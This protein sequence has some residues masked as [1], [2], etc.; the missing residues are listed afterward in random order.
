MESFFFT[1]KTTFC[2]FVIIFILFIKTG[3]DDVLLYYLEASKGHVLLT[4][5]ASFSYM[6]CITISAS[7][8]GIP[9]VHSLKQRAEND[10][11]TKKSWPLK[12][13]QVL[14]GPMEESG[15]EFTMFFGGKNF[16]WTA[17][18]K[19]KLAEF[20]FCLVEISRQTFRT[21]PQLI[22]ISLEDLQAMGEV[23]AEKHRGIERIY[24]GNIHVKALS[25]LFKHRDAASDEKDIMED[26]MQV[27]LMTGEEASDVQ[28]VEK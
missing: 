15:D 17:R 25:N 10:Y 12:A 18:N 20:L 23:W 28:F 16:L 3:N 8:S 14:E 22:K 26:R 4:S 9:R 21:V 24:A 11:H 19:D 1:S 27:P 13:L 6:L 7:N 2:E 5:A